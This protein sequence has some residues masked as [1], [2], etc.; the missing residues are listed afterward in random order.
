VPDPRDL[1]LQVS[2][3]NLDT[4]RRT[5]GLGLALV[6]ALLALV[7]SN[8]VG[9]HYTVTAL[10]AK[11]PGLYEGNVVVV[12]GV[13]VGKVT[14]IEPHGRTV[15]V[16]M[17][18]N[19]DVKL[20]ED[21]NAVLMPQSVVTD[22]V[23]EL[24]PYY[25]KGAAL[26]DGATIPVERTRTPVEFQDVIEAID[27]LSAQLG[28]V[29]HRTGAID[30]F[31]NVAADNARGNGARLQDTLQ[32]VQG[33]LAGFTANR[34]DTAT[35]IRQLARLTHVMA[36]SDETVRR[37]SSSV[38][39][40]SAVLADDGKGM[41]AALG[42]LLAALRDVAGFVTTHRR[43]LRAG[44]SGLAD[45]AEV[46]GS[47]SQE[48]AE[49]VDLLPLLMQNARRMVD[50]QR[51]PRVRVQVV[52]SIL[53]SGLLEGYCEAVTQLPFCSGLGLREVGPDLGMTELLTGAQP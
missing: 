44:I 35:L 19:G 52:N 32:G 21:V 39:E 15:E 23:V 25:E 1:G 6:M 26:G 49:I 33:A 50:P 22:R 37:F 36:S 45:A 30:D 46:L 51:G 11:T 27:D 40:A 13:P 31:M 10:F 14:T 2:R 4:A 41:N 3:M 29:E 16:T 47:R 53:N 18:I 48:I 38:T 17:E 43:S 34:D 42:E 28:K 5:I 7:A 8:R 12:L 20:P 9:D 24:T